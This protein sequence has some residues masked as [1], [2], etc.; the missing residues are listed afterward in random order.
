MATSAIWSRA[1]LYWL[2]LGTFA[3]GTEGFMIAPLLPGMAA[4]LSV[5]LSAAGAL[6]TVFALA[7]GLSSPLLTVATARSH[8][9]TLLIAA[10]I[11]FALAN[12]LAWA[13]R[14]YWG[15]MGARIMLALAAGLYTPNASALAGVLAPPEQRGRA[16]A[17]VNGGLTLAIVLG[18]P[19]GSLIGAAFGWRMTF[20]AVGMLAGIAVAGLTFGLPGGVGDHVPVVGLGQ[21]LSVAGRPDVLTGLVVTLFWASGTY[22]VWTYVAPFMDTTLGIRG[23]AMSGVVFLWGVAGAAGVFSGG[24]LNDRLGG[25]RVI[26]P[27]LSLLVF[28]FTTLW[29]SAT[30]LDPNTARVPILAAV[31]VWGFCSWAFFPAQV[32]RLIGLGGAPLAPVILSLNASFMFLG[33]SLGA[34]AGSIVLTYFQA[35][36]LGVIGG[37]FELAALLLYCLN[38]QHT[39]LVAFKGATAPS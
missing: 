24:Y 26:V 27:A 30:F 4:D 5:S 25:N 8:R 10:M 7:Y 32:A 34:Y 3:I 31:A 29:A 37:S 18:I 11:A 19:L 20:L 12:L 9:R 39:S 16:L 28:S 13:S 2:A 36:G 6:V 17:I 21:R 1:P 38:R 14:D 23:A 35:R 33:F 22:S 15:V